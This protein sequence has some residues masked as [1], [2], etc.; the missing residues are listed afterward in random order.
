MLR[1]LHKT[2]YHDPEKIYYVA[3]NLGVPADDYTVP[4]PEKTLAHLDAIA[5]CHNFFSEIYPVC[6]DEHLSRT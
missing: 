2:R 1:N 4:A 3:A 6:F 5:F